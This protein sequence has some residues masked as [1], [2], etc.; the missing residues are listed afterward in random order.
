MYRL[1][2]TGYEI[3]EAVKTDRGQESFLHTWSAK[4]FY[5]MISKATG[6]DMSRASDFKLLDRKAVLVLL[7]MKE[8]KIFFRALSSW[9]GFKSTKTEFAVQER[10]VGESKWSTWSLFKYVLSNVSSFSTAPM[11]IVTIMGA[12]MFVDSLSSYGGEYVVSENHWYC[13]RCF[14]TVILLLSFMGSLTMISLGIIGYYISQIYE[15][16]KGRPRYIISEECGNGEN[17]KL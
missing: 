3:V 2:E 4:C 17:D 7:N 6:I 10:A 11:Q 15:E 1:W 12:I 9:V 8:K 13:F 14:S 5:S 16:V